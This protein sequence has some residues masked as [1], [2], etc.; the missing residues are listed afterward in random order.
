MYDGISIEL[1]KGLEIRDHLFTVPYP[2]GLEDIVSAEAIGLKI[3]QGFWGDVIRDQQV[4]VHKPVVVA[5]VLIDNVAGLC[6]SKD[7]IT[8]GKEPFAIAEI[9]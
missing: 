6:F 9:I 2:F 1:H 8:K 7:A 4:V 5:E 3:I